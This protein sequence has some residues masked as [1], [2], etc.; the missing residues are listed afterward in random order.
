MVTQADMSG[1]ATA[2]RSVDPVADLIAQ[3]IFCV[4]DLSPAQTS[5][6]GRLEA[7]AARLAAARLQVA[8][9]G[10]FKRGKSSLLNAL[11]GM[12][13]LPIGVLLSTWAAARS[14]KLSKLP[15][16]VLPSR[17]MVPCPG[18]ARAACSSAAWRRKAVST[19]AGSSPWRM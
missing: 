16:S 7:L 10:Q 4:R 5:H 3:A 8:V 1:I 2:D 9:L 17:A 14:R 19:A 18:V 12:P 6:I 15:R 13:V 11:L